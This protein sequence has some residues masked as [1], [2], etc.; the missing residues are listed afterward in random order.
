MERMWSTIMQ[1]AGHPSRS[2]DPSVWFE[3][4]ER[5]YHRDWFDGR[6]TIEVEPVEGRRSYIR[7]I[8][9][10]WLGEPADRS[11]LDRAPN[12]LRLPLLG[13]WSTA[14]SGMNSHGVLNYRV[15][16]NQSPSRH[17]GTATQWFTT[18]ELWGFDQCI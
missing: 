14:N 10:G 13:R 7:I 9:A 6:N 8:P 1:L 17:V 12:E 3:A 5:L 2:G 16:P 15:E 18:G 4:G 11:Q